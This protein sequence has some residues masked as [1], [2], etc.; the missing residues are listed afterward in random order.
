MNKLIKSI[1]IFL[2]IYTSMCIIR[3]YP[4]DFMPTRNVKFKINSLY[5]EPI[6]ILSE[7]HIGTNVGDFQN[8]D[9]LIRGKHNSRDIKSYLSQRYKEGKQNE[10]TAIINGYRGYFPS[11]VPNILEI[12]CH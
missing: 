9:S 2:I 10:C 3:L 11:Q 5:G 7:F 8:R 4:V 12:E 6:V 1:V